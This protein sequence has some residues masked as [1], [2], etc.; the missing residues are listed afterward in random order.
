MCIPADSMDGASRNWNFWFPLLLTR[1]R[2]RRRG[3]ALHSMQRFDTKVGFW[4]QECLQ[5]RS[6][7]NQSIFG[8]NWRQLSES[9]LLSQLSQLL[10]LLIIHIYSFISI[11]ISFIR[12]YLKRISSSYALQDQTCGECHSRALAGSV[13]SHDFLANITMG[14]GIWLK[15]H[16]QIW[17]HEAKLSNLSVV[18]EHH[19]LWCSLYITPL[20][21]PN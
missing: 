5:S 21:C 7:C 18:F 17:K 8:E 2:R 15:H 11:S 4:P 12:P 14:F 6:L 3:S 10:L 9:S 1:R 16:R 13:I 19:S 20:P